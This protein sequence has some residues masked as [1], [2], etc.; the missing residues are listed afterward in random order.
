MSMKKISTFRAANTISKNKAYTYKDVY[1]ALLKKSCQ[2]RSPA[3]NPS[4]EVES[5]EG[6]TIAK[7]E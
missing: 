2:D 3:R 6:I 7:G 4:T 1:L 5:L